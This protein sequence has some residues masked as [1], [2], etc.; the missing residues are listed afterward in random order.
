MTMFLRCAFKAAVAFCV[1]PVMC[2][3]VGKINS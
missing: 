2:K 1:T 3:Y